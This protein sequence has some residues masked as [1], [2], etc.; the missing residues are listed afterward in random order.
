MFYF[1]YQ[2]EGNAIDVNRLQHA[3]V[4]VSSLPSAGANTKGSKQTAG[5]AMWSQPSSQADIPSIVSR[6]QIPKL[7]ACTM[8]AGDILM[9][10]LF[11][12]GFGQDQQQVKEK[13]SVDRFKPIMA[14]SLA[15]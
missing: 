6:Y 14:Q 1:K 5:K 3:D 9:Y 15:Q 2:L 8:T 12:A 10:G 11:Y 4:N 7:E 13:L